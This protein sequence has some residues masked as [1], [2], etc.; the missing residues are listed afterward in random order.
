MTPHEIRVLMA[1]MDEDAAPLRKEA[2]ALMHR[3]AME[4]RNDI[5]YQQ[6][7]GVADERHRLDL[8]LPKADERLS[9]LPIMLYLHGG[10]WV[11]GDKQQAAFKPLAFVPAG[12][13]F[14]SANYR[15][16]PESSLAEMA[17]SA[18]DAVAWLVKHADQFG[19][20][21]Q[22]L[23][24]IGHSAGAHLVSLLGTNQVF[25]QHAG[26]ALD[27]VRGIVSLDTIVYNIAKLLD[28]NPGPVHQQIFTGDEATL[29]HVSPW[30]HVDQDKA[31]PPFL[32]FYSEAR[33]E[34]LT[35]SIP[36]GERLR[37]A[38]HDAQ[39]VESV[40]RDHRMLDQR[41]GR[42]GDMY[43]DQILTFLQK[44]RH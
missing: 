25:L 14:A 6:I 36:F 41:L 39:V 29:Q 13:I 8:F 23:F 31:T 43:T 19:G 30:H 7:D 20:D 32:I 3:A 40:G 9:P 16:T 33:P 35:Q 37:A 17:Q 15:L 27:C 1:Q 10:A 12:F 44:H 34:G 4:V 42:E 22:Q 18:A 26:V 28:S 24:L 11:A 5:V 38:G 2:A 21:P